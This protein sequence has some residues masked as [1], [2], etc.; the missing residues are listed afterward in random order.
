MGG[1]CIGLILNN[2]VM[3]YA[4]SKAL[5][6]VVIAGCGVACGVVSCFFYIIIAIASTSLIGSYAVVRGA[7]AFIGH[8]PDEVT[9]IEQIKNGT[10]PKTSW[11]FWVYLIAICVLFIIGFFIQWK[12][13]PERNEKKKAGNKNDRKNGEYYRVRD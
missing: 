5:F 1:A 2:A 7:S 10:A 12:C 4:Q 3:R 9:I 6:W 8:F 11:Q 13:R